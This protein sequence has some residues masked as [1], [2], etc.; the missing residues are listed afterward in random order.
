MATEK[1][2]DTQT[3]ISIRFVKQFDLVDPKLP[4]IYDQA[5]LLAMTDPR[6]DVS[7]WVR[8]DDAMAF[9]R[10]QAKTYGV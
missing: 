3:G 2:D 6:W 10:E 9:L 7:Y 8:F 1:L 4:T 5:S